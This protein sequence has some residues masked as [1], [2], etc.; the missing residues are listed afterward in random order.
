VSRYPPARIP[1]PPPST[2]TTNRFGSRAMR[3]HVIAQLVDENDWLRGVEIGTADGRCT[4]QVLQACP[5][6]HMVTVD[7]WM[8]QPE[9]DGPEDWVGWPH[10]DHEMTA[11]AR[12]AP[13]GPRCRIIK[14]FSVDVAATVRDGSLDFVFLDGDHSEAGVRA[15][16]AAWRPKIR[17]GGMLT[18]HDCAWQ[19]VR[20]AIDDLCPGYWIAP[21]DVW[22]VAI[23]S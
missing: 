5:R 2:P 20:A 13:F 21:N 23:E 15:D 22:G 1:I 8:P 18:G 19:G 10:G 9:N 3:W 4:Q 14:A 16:I 11:R 12:L 17:R 6:L 7:P